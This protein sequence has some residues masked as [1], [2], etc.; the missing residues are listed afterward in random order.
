VFSVTAAGAEPLT[1]QWFFNTNAPVQGASDATLVLTD[2]AP[3][4]AGT[5]SVTVSN[6]AGSV[7]SQPA[8]LR[9]LIACEIVHVS[10]TLSQITLTF[11][12]SPGL[13]YTVEYNGDLNGSVWTLLPG[14]VKLN[15][16]GSPL[17]IQDPG[18]AAPMRFYR[19]RVE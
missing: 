7:S 2:V 14:A 19:I 4:D 10:R 8:A 18:P 15:G 17:T 3:A 1:Y 6:L 5:Y 16:T 11:T 13:R 12:T 9:V